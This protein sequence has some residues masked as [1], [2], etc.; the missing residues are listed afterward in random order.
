MRFYCHEISCYLCFFAVNCFS[1]FAEC[2]LLM[3]KKYEIKALKWK[4]NEKGK[5]RIIFIMKLLF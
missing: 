3:Y 2:R 4:E 5:I 1:C